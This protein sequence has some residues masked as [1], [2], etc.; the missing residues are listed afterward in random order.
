MTGPV[1]PD[2]DKRSEPLFPAPPPPE[3]MGGM[4]PPGATGAGGY[5]APPPMPP[6]AGGQPAPEPP[7]AVKVS[8]WIWIASAVIGVV[9]ALVSVTNRDEFTEQLRRQNPD[10]AEEQLRSTVN[11]ALALSIVLAVLVAAIYVFFAVKMRAGRNW[12][13]IT[14]TV[15]TLA[16]LVLQFAA[17][18]G[19]GSLGALVGLVAVVL[20]F[21]PSSNEYFQARRQQA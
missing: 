21:L 1:Q 15:V 13:R 18:G 9:M 19:I 11:A 6:E 7:M 20:M 3:S 14:L 16:F 5:P 8:F 17:T 4:P 12:A 2:N 10:L